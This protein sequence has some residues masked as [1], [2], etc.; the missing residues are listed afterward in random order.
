MPAD[1]F[2]EILK[3]PSIDL[4]ERAVLSISPVNSEDWRSEIIAY[5]QGRDGN[6]SEA[7]AMRM[8]KRTKQYRLIEGDPY[9][10]GV[11]T[12]LLRCVS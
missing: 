3:A 2:F 10:D 9:K 12:P 7:W 4:Q 5:L 6:T 1:V 8:A 11:T